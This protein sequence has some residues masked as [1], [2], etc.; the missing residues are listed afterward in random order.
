MKSIRE[1]FE[2]IWPVPK[3]VAWG[4]V[5]GAY[6]AHHYY[7]QAEATAHQGRLEAFN[8]C[9]ESMA[10]FMSLIDEM[11]MEIEGLA[12][13]AYGCVPHQSEDIIDRAKKLLEQHK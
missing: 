9:Q 11:V 8:R 10:P 5:L 4:S 12:I 3:G 6:F 2:E 7:D 13:E 1:Q